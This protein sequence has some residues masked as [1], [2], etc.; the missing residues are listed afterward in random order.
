MT[1]AKCVICDEAIT[2]DPSGWAGGH[3]AQPVATGQCCGDCNDKVVMVQ[4]LVDAGY[5]RPHALGLVASMKYR[6]L[7]SYGERE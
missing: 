7:I 2:P 1:V 3:N 5:T 6:E 4:R